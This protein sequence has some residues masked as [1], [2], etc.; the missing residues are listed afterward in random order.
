M[1]WQSEP[2]PNATSPFAVVQMPS[3]ALIDKLLRELDEAPGVALDENSVEIYGQ[4]LVEAARLLRDCPLTTNSVDRI[5]S[6]HYLLLMTAYA[7][8]A[9]VTNHDPLEPM[10]TAPGQF[11][12][13]DW[14][15]ASP[16]GVYRRAMV[17]DDCTYRVWGRLGNA[18][19]FS[20]DF[21][22][23]KP[24]VTLTRPDLEL[25]VEGNFEIFIGG[26]PR[27]RQWWPLHPGTSGLT[28]REFFD[29]WL[30][31][32]RSLLRIEC[33]DGRTAP[34]AEHNAARVAAEFDVVSDWILEGAIRFWM[35]KSGELEKIALNAFRPELERT[36]TKL[37]VVTTGLWMLAPDEALILEVPDPEADFWAFQLASSLWHTLDYANRFT[38]LNQAQ[39]QPDLDGIFRVV[40]SH[41]DPGVHNWLDAMSLERGIMILRF[42]GA[43]RASVPNTRLV[44]V[45]DVLEALPGAPRCTPDERRA[46]IAERREGI[47]RMVC[48]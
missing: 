18:S 7:V 14:G 5:D 33:L 46:Q 1:S 16:D 15:A 48:D 35:N 21:R 32:K 4:R 27:K 37:P 2:D 9:A 39:A 19:Y 30:L 11:H 43:H 34:R 6:F 38:S 3:S 28:T 47:A 45:S 44:K 8:E 31:A 20:M 42:C 26:E 10:W 29:D 13:I 41:S 22:Q 24:T 25:D 17:R 40:V 12:L 23:S 36:E